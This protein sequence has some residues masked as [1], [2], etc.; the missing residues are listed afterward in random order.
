[1]LVGAQPENEARAIKQT[2]AARA[3]QPGV[4][5]SALQNALSTRR[6]VLKIVE[7]PAA[8]SAVAVAT[9]DQRI[10]SGGVD[11]GTVR[12]WDAATGQPSGEL[13]TGHTDRVYSVA[14]SP[15][16]T[17]IVSG[18]ADKTV[19]LWD[20][21]TRQTLRILTGHQERVY[22]VA[23]SADGQRIVSGSADNTVRMWNADTGQPIGQPLTGHTAP[24]TSVA[25]SPDGTRIVSGSYDNTVRLWDADTGRPV[26]QP[27]TGHTDRVQSAAFSPDSSRIVSGG[28]DGTLR[29]WSGASS[30]PAAL[31]E[32]LCSKLMANIS[33]QQWREWVSPEIGYIDVCPGLPI[34]AD[35]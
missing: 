12:L 6:A 15:D 24:V 23:F 8:V 14:F 13:L 11:D 29:R 35:G 31:R 33:H 5:E 10:A 18:S 2:L 22:G 3:V 21:N 30:G 7:T 4:D 32:D 34:P 28:E 17:R 27:L 26:G 25:F 9:N 20:A 1:M 16:G 19:R